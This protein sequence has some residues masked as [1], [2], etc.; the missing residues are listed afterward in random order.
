MLHNKF[1]G[2]RSAGSGED[3]LPYMYIGV[4]GHLGHVT[5]MLRTKFRPP[6]QG[7]FDWP[8]GFGEDDLYTISSP[9]S[10]RLR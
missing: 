4:C 3:F 7:G 10:I 1:R 5:Q 8:S 2:N 6:T 9:M